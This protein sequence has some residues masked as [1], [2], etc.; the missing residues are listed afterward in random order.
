MIQHPA[1]RGLSKHTWTVRSCRSPG[2][3]WTGI[4][5]VVTSVRRRW[6]NSI[7]WPMRRGPPSQWSIAQRP[8]PTRRGGTC[9]APGQLAGAGWAA[10]MP[11]SPIRGWWTGRS[12][13]ELP[14]TIDQQ[15]TGLADAQRIGVR[16]EPLEGQVSVSFRR[17]AGGELGGNTDRG[18]SRDG[19]QSPGRLPIREWNGTDPC[20]DR[21]PRRRPA[22][23]DPEHC[24]SGRRSG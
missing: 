16:V 22:R 6:P 4:W 20:G 19:S 3:R 18:H 14:V 5:M 1:A 9:G 17:R 13:E 2:R 24:Y 10:A 8:R 7:P 23:R 21:R 12:S 15:V 11:G